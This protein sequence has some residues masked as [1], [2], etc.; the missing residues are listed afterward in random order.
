MNNRASCAFLQ[1]KRRFTFDA[2]DRWPLTEEEPM[3]GID[4]SAL[5]FVYHRRPA[6][7]FDAKAGIMHARAWMYLLIADGLWENWC[8]LVKEHCRLPPD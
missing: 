1:Q 4:P 3:R 8:Q 6:F 7:G 2:T 5:K